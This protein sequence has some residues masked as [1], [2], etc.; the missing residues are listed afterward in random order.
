MTDL[1]RLQWQQDLRR[2]ALQGLGYF[3]TL[4]HWLAGEN[5]EQTSEY[6][7]H[8]GERE[9]YYQWCD[10]L[11]SAIFQGVPIQ[12]YTEWK[13]GECLTDFSSRDSREC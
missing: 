3:P 13:T 8:H 12:D 9:T 6:Y 2:M 10:Y 7:T 5:A 1:D 11:K 4:A